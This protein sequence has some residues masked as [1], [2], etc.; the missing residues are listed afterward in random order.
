[1]LLAWSSAIFSAQPLTSAFSFQNRFTAALWLSQVPLHKMGPWKIR[2]AIN[3]TIFK[4][5]PPSVFTV[6]SLPCKTYPMGARLHLKRCTTPYR[7]FRRALLIALTSD[8]IK[9]K[10]H[11]E[12]LWLCWVLSG[13]AEAFH[14]QFPFNASH[15]T[16]QSSDINNWAHHKT[17]NNGP[18]F[19]FDLGA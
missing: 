18:S 15:L 3:I 6:V 9:T 12:Q 5:L 17:L 7:W 1:M 14:V 4:G 10:H 13:N 19:K 8:V 16:H 11:F 2:Y